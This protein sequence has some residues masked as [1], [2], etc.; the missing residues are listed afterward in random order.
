MAVAN[1]EHR[2]TVRALEAKRDFLIDARDRAKIDL[3]KTRVQ[4]KAKRKAKGKGTIR[5][6][7][8]RALEAR[9]DALRVKQTT[10]GER[11]GVIRA[12][13]KQVRVKK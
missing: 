8:I 7:G 9:V 11:L 6:R 10:A 1:I 2:R 4:L 12:E 3:I 13:L 5:R